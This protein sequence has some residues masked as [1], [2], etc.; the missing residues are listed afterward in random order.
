MLYT[1]MTSDRGRVLVDGIDAARDPDAVRRRRRAARRARAVTKRL[2]ARENIEY[3][4][5]LH[6]ID[7]ATLRSRTDALIAALEM[8]DIA[9]R[10]T[11]GF[12]RPARQDRHRPR[13]GA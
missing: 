5:R 6:G 8:A 7:A 2:S 3:F 4:G 11:E 10:K 13:P 9:A 12:S 1:L